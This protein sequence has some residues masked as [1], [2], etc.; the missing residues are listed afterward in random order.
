MLS[1]EDFSLLKK[2]LLSISPGSNPFK[3]KVIFINI[4]IIVSALR[5]NNTFH[6]CLKECSICY[7]ILF[8]KVV[9]PSK[10]FHLFCDK[11]LNK[12]SKSSNSCPICRSKFTRIISEF[13][14]SPF[15]F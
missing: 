4:I 8:F 2:S 7:K 12:W 13:V 3:G 14:P 10:C 15:D 1:T 11:C 6:N 9:R 5:N